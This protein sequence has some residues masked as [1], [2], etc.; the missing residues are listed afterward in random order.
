MILTAMN[1]KT[2]KAIKG[3]NEAGQEVSVTC[4]VQQLLGDI[5]LWHLTVGKL[6]IHNGANDLGNVADICFFCCSDH[7]FA[8]LLI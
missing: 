3:K 6:Y 4:E 2:T 5:N 8:Y 7:A 1:I